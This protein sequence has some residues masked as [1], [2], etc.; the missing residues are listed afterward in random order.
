MNNSKAPSVFKILIKIVIALIIGIIL[1]GIG[2]SVL[3]EVADYNEDRGNMADKVRGCDRYYY[4]KQYGELRDYLMLYSL[5][6][7]EFDIY[8]EA[9]DGF[10][11]YQ[12]YRQWLRAEKLQTPD[13]EK[14]TEMYRQ[15]VLDRA[16]NCVF[17]K[18]KKQME[19]YA[20]ELDQ[21]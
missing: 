9:A 1:F 14:M 4:D 15:K 13:A 2:V 6:G 8:W 18:N 10:M 20:L 17:P 21:S 12:Q 19:A 11:D 16:E 3:E 7:G 5:Y